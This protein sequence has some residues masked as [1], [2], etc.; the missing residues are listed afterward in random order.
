MA[1][2]EFFVHVSKLAAADL[3]IVEHLLQFVHTDNCACL[4]SK[5]AL[6][7]LRLPARSQL[8]PCLN[9]DRICKGLGHQLRAVNFALDTVICC[10]ALEVHGG[11]GHEKGVTLQRVFYCRPVDKGV[12][13]KIRF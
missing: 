12:F 7:H 4:G 13:V 8:L 3:G 9:L 6:K 2:S 5:L 11:F 10:C 1:N